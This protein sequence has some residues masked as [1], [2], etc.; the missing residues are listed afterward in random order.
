MEAFTLDLA[1][2]QAAERFAPDFW[3]PG[4]SYREN[5]VLLAACHSQTRRAQT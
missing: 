1:Q 2:M 5:L 3:V 4:H